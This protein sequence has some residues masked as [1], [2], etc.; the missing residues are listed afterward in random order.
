MVYQIIKSGRINCYR[1]AER[2]LRATVTES[3]SQRILMLGNYIYCNASAMFIETVMSQY[4]Y[5]WMTIIWLAMPYIVGQ[6]KQLHTFQRNWATEMFLGRWG[7]QEVPLH[8]CC[9]TAWLPENEHLIH[10]GDYKEFLTIT[11]GGCPRQSIS[12]SYPSLVINWPSLH[13]PGRRRRRSGS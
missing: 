7:V 11:R 13:C 1:S 6:I 3:L 2:C 10:R 4:M 8:Q 9:G 5:R 12:S